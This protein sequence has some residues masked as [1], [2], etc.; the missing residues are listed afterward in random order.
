MSYLEHPVHWGVQR[1]ALLQGTSGAH[2]L[3]CSSGPKQGPF[4]SEIRLL[5]DAS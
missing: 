3:E 2:A 1:S 5:V 4:R